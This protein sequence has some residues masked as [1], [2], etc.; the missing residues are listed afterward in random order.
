MSNNTKPLL[1]WIG[2]KTQI[3]DNILQKF[4]KEI[5]DYHEIFIGGGSVLLG[6]LDKIKS[7]EIKLTGKIYAYDLNEDLIIF[8][9]NI[10]S[11]PKQ[12]IKEINIMTNVYDNIE[13]LNNGTKNV[14]PDTVEDAVLSK[15]SYYYWIRSIFNEMS[16]KERKT[17]LASAILL[18]LNKSGFRGLYRM[19]KNGFNVPFGNYK[20]IYS[21]DDV[22]IM[23]ISKLIKNVV[24]QHSCFSKSIVNIENK[25]LVFVYLD[26]PYAPEN[27]SSFVD[28]TSD[29]FDINQHKLL[30]K[31]CDELKTKKINFLMSNSDVDLVNAHFVNYSK[32]TILCKRSI[33]S[34]KPNSKT[35]ELLIT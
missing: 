22:D 2:G 31:L 3:L 29:G 10:Q 17:P 30:F 1:K 28:Y 8:Y 12:V 16:K 15:E 4:P 6:L 35:N 18:F 33:N 23:N 11:K 19:S 5:S 24:F 34:K 7:N 13:N 32:E 27:E 20:K 21:I 14:I 26:P 25:P 9:K